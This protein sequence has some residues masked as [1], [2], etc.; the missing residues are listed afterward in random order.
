MAG[1]A[2][3]MLLAPP[4][5]HEHVFGPHDRLIILTRRRRGE[6]EGTDGGDFGGGR[7]GN[8]NKGSAEVATKEHSAI[9]EAKA[10]RSPLNSSPS[11]LSL[12]SSGSF[13]L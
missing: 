9:E 13:S 3:D 7:M 4:A 12:S 10:V 11:P 8:G 5:D 6:G 2:G 1:R